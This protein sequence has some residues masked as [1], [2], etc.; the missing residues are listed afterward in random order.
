[1]VDAMTILKRRYCLNT[2][3]HRKSLKMK[4]IGCLVNDLL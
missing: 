1:M 3:I 4:D 2:D